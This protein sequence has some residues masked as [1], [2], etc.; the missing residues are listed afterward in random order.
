M[1]DEHFLVEGIECD[2]HK[3]NTILFAENCLTMKGSY[4]ILFFLDVSAIRSY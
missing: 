1:I 3:K 4:G 2:F